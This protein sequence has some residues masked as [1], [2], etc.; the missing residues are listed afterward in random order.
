M[1]CE[2][3]SVRETPRGFRIAHVK[4]GQMYGDVPC[5]R[6]FSERP[7]A[8][9]K[10]HLRVRNGRFEAVLRVQNEE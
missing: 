6:Q 4:V 7:Q 5:D 3:L 9:L 10:P 2:V 1:K 8:E